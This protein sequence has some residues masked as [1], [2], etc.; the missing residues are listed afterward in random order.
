MLLANY[1][2]EEQTIEL[3]KPYSK[4]LLNNC[5]E[6]KHEGDKIILQGYQALILEV[7]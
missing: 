6:V 3:S 2:K 5:D 1:Q 4:V 7:L